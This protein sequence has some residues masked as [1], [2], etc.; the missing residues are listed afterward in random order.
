MGSMGNIISKAGPHRDRSKGCKRL[1]STTP[2]S[3]P[4]TTNCKL[5]MS[6]TE[7]AWKTRDGSRTRSAGMCQRRLLFQ[8]VLLLQGILLLQGV[9]LFQRVLLLQRVLLH[10]VSMYHR[11]SPRL[12]LQITFPPT[13]RRPPPR[14]LRHTLR[15]CRRCQ[16]P[17]LQRQHSLCSCQL[18]L[19]P[20]L[21]QLSHPTYRFRWRSVL[22]HQLDSP[23]SRGRECSRAAI[24]NPSQADHVAMSSGQR[25][26]KSAL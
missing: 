9:L 12:L 24:S 8:R 23:T 22:R 6:N 2:S 18:R 26:S 11:S 1:S 13:C 10:L 3:K 25:T 16:P 15:T 20:H 5:N 17:Y 4:R 7:C 21:D 19:Q 14:L